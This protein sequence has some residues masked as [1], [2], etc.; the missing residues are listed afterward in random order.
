MPLQILLPLQYDF[1]E[2]LR[3]SMDRILDSGSNDWGSTPHGDT[4]HLFQQPNK[5][6]AGIAF[7]TTYRFEPYIH[8]ARPKIYLLKPG[9]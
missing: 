9:R 2:C 1:S 3:S 8:R 6:A 5:Q 4:K 7:Y